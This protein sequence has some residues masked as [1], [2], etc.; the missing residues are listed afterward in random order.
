VLGRPIL[1]FYQ[2][3]FS[4]CA[5][6]GSG[7]LIVGLLV[8][9]VDWRGCTAVLDLEGYSATASVQQRDGCDW[10]S[11]KM[12]SCKIAIKKLLLTLVNLGQIFQ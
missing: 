6:C 12:N 2:A 11:F 8:L 3:R 9:N 4:R 7:G 5:D 1:Y 10:S